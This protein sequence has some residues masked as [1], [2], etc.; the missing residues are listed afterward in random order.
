MNRPLYPTVLVGASDDQNMPYVRLIEHEIPEGCLLILQ[1]EKPSSIE[2]SYF[3]FGRTS[4]F[5]S[6][7]TSER[8]M[9]KIGVLYLGN[10]LPLKKGADV[11]EGSIDSGLFVFA[12]SGEIFVDQA[13]IREYLA[14]PERA[15]SALRIAKRVFDSRFS[16]TGKRRHLKELQDQLR[17]S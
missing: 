17:Q 5:N 8:L 15:T 11:Y 3:S 4:G 12:R 6:I 7:R 16:Y 2:G 9:G 13:H 1:K 14:T 10:D